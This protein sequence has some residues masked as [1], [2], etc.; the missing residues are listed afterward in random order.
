MLTNNCI[1]KFLSINRDKLLS[2][3]EFVVSLQMTGW[4]LCLYEKALKTV[5]E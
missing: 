5:I 1:Y 3:H 4:F 2:Q